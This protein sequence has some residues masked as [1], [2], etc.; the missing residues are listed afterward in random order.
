MAEAALGLVLAYLALTVVR[1]SLA[2]SHLRAGERDEA[3]VAEVTVL[4]AIR[5]G[6]PLMPAM[7]AENAASLARAHLVWLVDVDDPAGVEAARGAAAAATGRVDVVLTPPPGAGV[8]PKVAKLVI[9]LGLCGPL[10]AVLDDDTVLPPGALGRAV[11][12]LGGGDLVTGV[13]V[14]REH[15][16]WWSRLVAAFVN[17][18]SVATYPTLA[19]LGDPVTIN[20]MFSV[21]RRTVLEGLGGFAAIQDRV[22]DDYELALL[23]RRAGLRIVQSPVVVAVGTTVAGPRA[24]LRIMRRWMIFATQVVRADLGLAMALLVLLPSV[25]PLVA[26]VLAVASHRPAA[27][28][29]VVLACLVKAGLTALVR[30]SHPPAPWSLAG[31]VPEVV[32]DL[33]TPLHVLGSAVGSRTVAWRDRSVVVPRDA[34]PPQGTARAAG[35]RASRPPSTSPRRRRRPRRGSPGRAPCTTA[36]CHRTSSR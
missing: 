7:L 26:L 30:R 35:S 17:G 6:D 11:A 24:Y 1:L 27:V 33:L 21:T 4:Q 19:R 22:C 9:G 14:Y 25:L 12:A 16:G 8:N 18:S 36:T 28:G 34:G 20:G 10:V 15:G 23:F 5:S 2:V 29:V 3:P 32:A 31:L 13:P